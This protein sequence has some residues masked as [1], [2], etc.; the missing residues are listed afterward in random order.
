[1]KDSQVRDDKKRNIDRKDREEIDDRGARFHEGYARRK[2]ALAGVG[3][4]FRRAPNAQHIFNG[5]DGDG[6]IFDPMKQRAVSRKA[7]V[8]FENDRKNG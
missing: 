3:S 5:E 6:E 4:V 8:R 1:M 7:F 2:F